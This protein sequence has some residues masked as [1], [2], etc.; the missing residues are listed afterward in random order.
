[1]LKKNSL[2][3]DE[4]YQAI[5]NSPLFAILN[6][7]TDLEQIVHVIEY[8]VDES[9]IDAYMATTSLKFGEYRYP[10]DYITL[11]RY[12]PDKN[13]Q[14]GSY[15]KLYKIIQGASKNEPKTIVH[16]LKHMENGKY[17]FQERLLKN[18]YEITAIYAINEIS[19]FSAQYIN[20][21]NPNR[22]LVLDAVY[23][24]LVEFSSLQD[25]YISTH[26]QNATKKF[27]FNPDND[28]SKIYLDNYMITPSKYSHEF[29]DI[30]DKYFTFN[31]QKMLNTSRTIPN[32]LAEKFTHLS[33]T[34]YSQINKM[35]PKIL[36]DFLQMHK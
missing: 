35:F 22:T 15:D 14:L 3:T 26:I 4:H 25:S 33:H 24:G 16:E 20:T 6:N 31:G 27:L 9:N 5:E 7:I 36:D 8:V 19:A 23:Y 2:F 11:F 18:F 17:I 34:Y 1:M 13:L 30:F 29:I 10:N 28:L 12:T 32:D 21:Q